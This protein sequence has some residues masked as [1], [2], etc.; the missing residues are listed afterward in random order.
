MKCVP[1]LDEFAKLLRGKMSLGTGLSRREVRI[2]EN[3]E[4]IKILSEN[5]KKEVLDDAQTV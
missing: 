2:T 3:R 1:E 4:I 5:I